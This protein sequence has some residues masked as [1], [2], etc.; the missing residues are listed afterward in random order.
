VQKKPDRQSDLDAITSS[1]GKETQT[2]VLALAMMLGLKTKETGE[3]QPDAADFMKEVYAVA[4]EV[5]AHHTVV[6]DDMV[7]SVAVEAAR[8]RQLVP[9]G[10]LSSGSQPVEAAEGVVVGHHSIVIDGSGGVP[11]AADTP[12]AAELVFRTTPRARAA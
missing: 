8:L 9:E 5:A 2:S 4:E 12:I 1:Q 6:L 10:S 7:D 3:R 11:I